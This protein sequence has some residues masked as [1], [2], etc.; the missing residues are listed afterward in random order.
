MN[1]QDEVLTQ[2]R[3]QTALLETISRQLERIEWLVA[4]DGPNYTHP[5]AAY[6][7][8]DWDSI[9]AVVSGRDRDGVNRVDWFGK[10]FTRRSGSGKFGK[11]IWFSRYTGEEAG[12]KKYARLITFKDYSEAEPVPG[13]VARAN[14]GSK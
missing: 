3:A 4:P 9:G 5:L 14:G 12:E 11:A 6:P 10:T 2:M 7:A 13:E 8:F 1:Y